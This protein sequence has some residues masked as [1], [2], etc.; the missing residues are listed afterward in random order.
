MMNYRARR[1]SCDAAVARIA[2]SYR[3]WVDLFAKAK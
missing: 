3:E 1:I 2:V